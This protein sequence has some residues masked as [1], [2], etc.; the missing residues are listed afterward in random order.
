M[1]GCEKAFWDV[2]MLGCAGCVCV[3]GG[4]GDHRLK[5]SGTNNG[6]KYDVRFGLTALNSEG[7]GRQAGGKRWEGGGGA[8][9][10]LWPKLTVFIPPETQWWKNMHACAEALCKLG[11]MIFIE[12]GI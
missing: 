10:N 5:W 1:T 12:Q 9:G 7:R 3:L 11:T 6:A 4:G 8:M 2:A